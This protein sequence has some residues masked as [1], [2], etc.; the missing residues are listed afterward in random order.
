MFELSVDGTIFGEKGRILTKE[1]YDNLILDCDKKYFKNITR[2]PKSKMDVF[3]VSG[4]MW[5]TI[6]TSNRRR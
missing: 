3:E 4:Q 6:S 1:E 5:Q 2:I